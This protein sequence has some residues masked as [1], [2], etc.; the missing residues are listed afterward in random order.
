MVPRTAF[1]V[2]ARLGCVLLG[3]LA[4]LA[5]LGGVPKRPRFQGDEC[6]CAGMG[7]GWCHDG[8]RLVTLVELAPAGLSIAPGGASFNVA[9]MVS[10]LGGVPFGKLARDSN[11]RLHSSGISVYYSV[12]ETIQC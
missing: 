10:D 8:E 2:S 3:R 1:R 9:S 11:Y 4:G 5:I 6:H 7:L 12:F